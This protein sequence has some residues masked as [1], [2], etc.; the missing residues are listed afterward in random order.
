L[1]CKVFVKLE[2]EALSEVP[3]EQNDVSLPLPFRSPRQ[4]PNGGVM[5]LL[6]PRQNWPFLFHSARG[7]GSFLLKY[8]QS[9][10]NKICYRKYFKNSMLLTK[11]TTHLHH[12]WRVPHKVNLAV[13]TLSKPRKPHREERSP[14]CQKEG[15]ICEQNTDDSANSNDKGYSFLTSRK[16][17]LMVQMMSLPLK[18]IFGM[19][20][21]YV[22][23]VSSAAFSDSTRN[24]SQSERSKK[25]GKVYLP[26]YA[27]IM[28]PKKGSVGTSFRAGCGGTESLLGT[29]E[30]L[31]L[32]V[33][34]KPV[35][36]AEKER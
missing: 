24:C 11:R 30:A 8:L 3:L 36:G 10:R 33:E 9:W 14:L 32:P 12:L 26:E 22:E 2:I 21:Q 34:D 35:L 18:S 25:R 20:A 23:N 1:S 29:G 16:I 15:R 4:Q 27:E 13:Y 17:F 28:E 5:F 6:H 31:A 7:V 19:P